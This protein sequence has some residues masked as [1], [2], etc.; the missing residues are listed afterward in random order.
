[1]L[2]GS[3]LYYV[4]PDFVFIVRVHG[5]RGGYAKTRAP[6]SS[7]ESFSANGRSLGFIAP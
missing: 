4:Q 2:L 1:M 3:G 5:N 7:S 6:S